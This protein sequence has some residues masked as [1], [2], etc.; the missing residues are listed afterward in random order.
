MEYF[1]V[2]QHFVLGWV[3]LVIGG[4]QNKTNM[5]V[6]IGLNVLSGWITNKQRAKLCIH[7]MSEYIW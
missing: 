1:S 4:N 6:S 3:I 2:F 7:M 5:K